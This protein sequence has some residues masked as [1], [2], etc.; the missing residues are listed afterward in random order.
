VGTENYSEYE[1]NLHYKGIFYCK[2][3]HN[4]LHM[5][6][7]TYIYSTLRRKRKN[8]KTDLRMIHC[9]EKKQMNQ[10]NSIGLR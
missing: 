4:Y 6:S 7:K 1:L 8:I 9:G 3:N 2:L 5:Y 10:W